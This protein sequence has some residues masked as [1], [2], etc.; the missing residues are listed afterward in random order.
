MFRSPPPEVVVTKHSRAWYLFWPVRKL[1][2]LLWVI[3]RG[4]LRAKFELVRYAIVAWLAGLTGGRRHVVR[5]LTL[6]AVAWIPFPRD[7]LVHGAA[8]AVFWV[9]YG[10]RGKV[11]GW[12]K[13]E[14]GILATAATTVTLWHLAFAA[15][16]GFEVAAGPIVLGV[17]YLGV[18]GY[19]AGLWIHGRRVR[20]PAPPDPLLLEWASKVAP[21][22][23][24][25]PEIPVD[26]AV[27]D[28]PSR[29]VPTELGLDAEGEFT[30]WT[31]TDGGEGGTG[32]LRLTRT[33]A[34]DVAKLDEHAERALDLR[35]GSV[36]I[37]ADPRLSVRE[38]RIHIT[39][40]PHAAAERM[41]WFDGLTL[42][43]DG[44]FVIQKRRD[45]SPVYGRH[46]KPQS[47]SAVHVGYVAPSEGGKG[48]AFRIHAIEAAADP[49]TCRVNID[50]K[51]GGG[52]PYMRHGAAHHV[53]KPH[54]YLPTLEAYH[55]AMMVRSSLEEERGADGWV[56]SE[57]APQVD[58][59]ADE[60]PKI[61]AQGNR[62][63]QARA[64]WLIL[65]I[66]QTGRSLG[67]DLR[68]TLQKG[69]DAG[70]GSTTTRMNVMQNAGWVWLGKVADVGAK[71]TA[72]QSLTREL[73]IDPVNL[74]DGAGWAYVTGGALAGQAVMEARTL[75]LPT[76]NDVERKKME[77]PYGTFEDWLER[78][79]VQTAWHPKEWTAFR[80]TFER[81]AE[82]AE[83]A[84]E[85]AESAG[86]AAM[87]P[88][89]G[90]P[91]ATGGGD[92]E[93]G[94]AIFDPWAV[95]IGNSARSAG[96]GLATVTQIRQAPAPAPKMP[97]GRLKVLAALEEAAEREEGRVS[98]REIA[99][100]TE[101]HLS[102]VIGHLEKLAADGYADG[103]PDEGWRAA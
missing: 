83:K 74:P 17:G 22:P 92:G 4:L 39:R 84:K 87:A 97:A 102:T 37:S 86:S 11:R 90:S 53:S 42:D 43:N 48:A 56:A 23:G 45:G 20:A 27:P 52:I 33:R 57:E 24:L 70:W 89:Q 67:Y 93:A 63:E 29:Y 16:G 19:H 8:A 6:L 78:Y 98:A 1:V 58:L 99:R 26:P 62:K 91:V 75:Y 80:T 72:Y 77:S 32:V 88:P 95:P 96:G 34:S 41:V 38:V 79:G 68:A 100:R 61:H 85:K 65:D 59:W 14:V 71:N 69:D 35:R 15:W 66:S 101:L 30:E 2:W 10:T 81:H 9:V 73:G 21:V 36:V 5:P 46:R 25:T 76:R 3:A 55:A 13:R 82:A 103:G 47:G 49:L 64:K 31:S 18:L 60:L 50:G 40:D 44:R 94:G 28:G 12:S 51:G 7:W 54:L